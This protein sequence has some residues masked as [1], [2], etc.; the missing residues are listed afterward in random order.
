M[1]KQEIIQKLHAQYAQFCELVQNLSPEAFILQPEGKWSAAQQ[2]DHL[3]R[4]VRPVVLGLSLPS[5]LLRLV[6]GR[7]KHTSRDYDTLVK[8]YQ[9]ALA[10]GGKSPK[11]YEPNVPGEGF[12]SFGG[13]RL[14]Q[15]IAGLDRLLESL[16]EA[17][18]D[19]LQAPHPLLGKLTLRELMYFTIYHAQHHQRNVEMS[20]A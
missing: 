3:V 14:M 17:D 16:S 9:D 8:T 2:L 6:F 7:A 11:A 4:S 13:E 1:N 5:F 19:T 18:L 15:M 10:K 20:L 12:Q